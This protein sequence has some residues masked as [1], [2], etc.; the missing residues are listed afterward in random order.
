MHEGGIPT[1]APGTPVHFSAR[2]WQGNHAHDFPAAPHFLV[3]YGRYVLVISG[4]HLLT[5]LIRTFLRTLMRDFR[6][7]IKLLLERIIAV[8]RNE[9]TAILE[10]H[11]AVLE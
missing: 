8:R 1:T 7:L 5:K 4:L 6:S 9:E 2:S 11:L 10:L 3:K